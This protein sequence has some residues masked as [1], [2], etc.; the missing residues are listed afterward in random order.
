MSRTKDT[1]AP[2][3]DATFGLIKS[4]PKTRTLGGNVTTTL[5]NLIV[6][7]KLPPGAPLGQESLARS[8]GV[9]RLPIREGLQQ[10]ASEGLVVLEPH[11]GAVVA[12]LSVE[13]FDELYAVIWSLEKQATMVGVPKLTSAHISM[14]QDIFAKL[15]VADD[16]AD[17][18]GLSVE[19]HRVI[20]IASG[21]KRALRMA[22]EC[23][24]NIQRYL[25]DKDFFSA[26]VSVWVK[27]N[28]A[29]L[30]ACKR[31]DA[32]AAVEALEVMRQIS[33]KQI[34]EH[35]EETL[36]NIKAT[37]LDHNEPAV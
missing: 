4:L 3:A 23:R 29:L 26:N 2:S 25:L 15:R 22:D 33:T 9:S 13:E 36:K 24:L 1:A 10:L 6:T 30:K 31:R 35:A 14:M 27:R 11:R 19:L 20:F 16:P 37:Q 34:R 5:R 21:W 18:Y 7:G 12:P 28:E 17:W 32:E 8:F